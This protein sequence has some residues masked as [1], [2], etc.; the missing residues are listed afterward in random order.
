MTSQ[1]VRG[2]EETLP[3]GTIPGDA[4]CGG[5]GVLAG[6]GMVRRGAPLRHSYGKS[7]PLNKSYIY[8]ENLELSWVQDHGSIFVLVVVVGGG[9]VKLRCKYRSDV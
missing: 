1:S 3:P 9:G 6:G 8:C 5:W 4:P 7:I 2:L